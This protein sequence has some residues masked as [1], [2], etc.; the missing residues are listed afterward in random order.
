MSDRYHIH[1]VGITNAV[2][3]SARV[4]RWTGRETITGTQTFVPLC[5]RYALDPIHNFL[6]VY[7]VYLKEFLAFYRIK[8]RDLWEMAFAMLILNTFCFLLFV[9][10]VALYWKLS[11]LKK[12]SLPKSGSE[13]FNSGAHLI[14]FS[15]V[16]FL[17][18]VTNCVVDILVTLIFV[19]EC[20][21][22]KHR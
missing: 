7:F 6:L 13:N 1:V 9:N 21:R 22:Y 19:I 10:W 11:S 12:T 15:H 18:C 3:V 17:T 16:I 14:I 20:C 4:S 8:T 2:R 5:W